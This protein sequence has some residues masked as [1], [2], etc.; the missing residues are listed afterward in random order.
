MSVGEETTES[1]AIPSPPG[2]IRERTEIG[3]A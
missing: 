2:Q 3:M 1:M